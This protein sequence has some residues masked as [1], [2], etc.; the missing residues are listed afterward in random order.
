MTILRRL[1]I[2]LLLM[3]AASESQAQDSKQVFI[4]CPNERAGLHIAQQM[5]EG[6]QELG[7]L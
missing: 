2:A 4:Y 1:G 6:W 3:M 5:G 7:Q